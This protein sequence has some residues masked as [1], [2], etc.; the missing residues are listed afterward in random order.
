[1]TP[2]LRSLNSRNS[3]RS[4]ETVAMDGTAV[5]E[6]CADVA[7]VQPLQSWGPRL[8]SYAARLLSSF[9]RESGCIHWR[10]VL[11]RARVWRGESLSR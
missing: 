11:T 6:Y 3:G 7:K 5:C 9:S 8:F 1:V 4:T 2:V 10:P